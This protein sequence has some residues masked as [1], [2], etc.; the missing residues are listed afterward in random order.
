VRKRKLNAITGLKF[1]GFITLLACGAAQA[2]G[3][4]IGLEYEFEKDKKTG[5]RSDAFALEPGWEFPKGSLIN[6]V[7]LLI[8]RSRD[9]NA[10]SDG[11]REKETKLF[12]RI[13]HSRSLTDNLAYYVRGGI[14]R[15]LSNEDDF[16]YAYMEAGLQYEIGP[17]WEWTAGLREINAIDGTAGER[18]GK[19]ITGPSFSFDKNNEVELRYVRAFRDKD[20][21]AWQIGYTHS[22]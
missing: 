8:D 5:M 13:R 18:V 16:T 11:F 22:F 17:R 6:L 9:R 1:V 2:E 14:G 20:T 15:S 19:F 10:D 21:R 7:E 3:L 4:R 12:V